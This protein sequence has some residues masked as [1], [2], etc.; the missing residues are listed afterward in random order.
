M[1]NRIRSTG[2]GIALLLNQGVATSIAAVFLPTV[3][4]YGYAAMFLTWG[5]A[6]VVYFLIAAFI[7]PETKNRTLEEIERGFDK[8]H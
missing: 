4:A 7:L 1:P 5:A 3:G 6:T 2:M 8:R